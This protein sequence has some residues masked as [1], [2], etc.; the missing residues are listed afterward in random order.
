MQPLRSST[1]TLRL[2]RQNAA[3]V[4]VL[5][6][7]LVIAFLVGPWPGGDDWETFHGAARRVLSGES[8]YETR[9]THAYY[10]NPPWLAVLFVPLGVL[11]FKLGWAILSAAS[12]GAALLLLHR[13]QPRAGI[14][15]P[16]LVLLS[17]PMIYILMHGQI[18]VL[19]ISGVWLPAQYWAVVA[20]TKPQVAIGLIAGVPRAQWVR[21]GLL[22]LGLVALSL[23]VFGNWIA[24]FLD[25][26]APYVEAGHN[27]WRDL[28][29]FQV[30]AGVAL[31]L[32]GMSRKDERLL[33]SGSPLLS[34]YAATSTLIGPWIAAIT[35]LSNRQATVVFLSWWAA[36]VYRGLAGG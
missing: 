6:A 3:L 11:P 17:P 30:P 20:L 26:P 32:L 24:A 21:A 27:L 9:I 13:W 25:Q 18:D 5:F 28:W 36:V 7:V 29:P 35:L 2:P 15:K 4:I 14:V 8:L 19:V 16:V 22:T 33:I 1:S 10:S 31:V 34:P 23:L 12:L